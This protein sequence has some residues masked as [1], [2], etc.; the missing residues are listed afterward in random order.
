MDL[1]ERHLHDNPRVEIRVGSDLVRMFACGLVVRGCDHASYCEGHA[2]REMSSRENTTKD[3]YISNGGRWQG[4]LK[5][6]A[7]RTRYKFPR[8]L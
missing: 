4:T 8:T 7:F 2:D 6:T 5:I 1:V 3:A